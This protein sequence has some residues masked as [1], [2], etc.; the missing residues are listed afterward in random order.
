MFCVYDVRSHPGV[1]I[2]WTPK[3]KT[4]THIS[5]KTSFCD[6][7]EKSFRVGMSTVVTVFALELPPQHSSKGSRRLSD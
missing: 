7:C 4:R 2:K 6:S 1:C 5:N 3:R